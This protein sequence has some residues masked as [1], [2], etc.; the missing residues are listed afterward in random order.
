MA[1]KQYRVLRDCYWNGRLYHE[2][3]RGK[4]NVVEIEEK[5]EP[6]ANNFE[7][8]GGKVAPEPKPAPV[9]HPPKPKTEKA[10][11]EKKK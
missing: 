10:E 8:T 1:V 4:P 5:L 6:P 3:E 2:V 9:A 11:A 7:L